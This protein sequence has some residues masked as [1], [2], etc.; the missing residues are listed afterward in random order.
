MDIIEYF[1]GTWNHTATA[2]VIWGG[3][4][5]SPSVTASQRERFIK[6]AVYLA[7]EH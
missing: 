2:Y 6:D 3:G 5:G 4:G 7:V 1:L